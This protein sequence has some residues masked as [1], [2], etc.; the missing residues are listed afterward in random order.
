MNLFDKLVIVNFDSNLKDYA[1]FEKELV[2]LNI[3]LSL[4][5]KKNLSLKKYLFLFLF[6]FLL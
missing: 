4:K 2:E 6:L 5:K 1:S 3:N